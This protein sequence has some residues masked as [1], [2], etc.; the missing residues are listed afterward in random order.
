MLDF[1][2]ADVD[3]LSPLN[4][5][6]VWTIISVI[7]LLIVLFHDKPMYSRGNIISYSS[8]VSVDESRSKKNSLLVD[9]ELIEELRNGIK[10]AKLDESKFV[11]LLNEYN[12][13]VRAANELLDNYINYFGA[14]KKDI[15]ASISDSN[16]KASILL[17]RGNKTG[18]LGIGFIIFS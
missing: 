6:F 1:M 11:A 10:G 13:N 18:Y 8:L 4:P 9:K 2:K 15:E 7:G 16:K 14:V 3:F 17:E 5:I 12:D